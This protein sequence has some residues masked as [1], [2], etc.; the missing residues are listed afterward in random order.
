MIGVGIDIGTRALLAFR[1]GPA[2]PSYPDIRNYVAA[3]DSITDSERGGT[4][5]GG[6]YA[7]AAF[8]L[9][10]PAIATWHNIALSGSGISTLVD[11]AADT[12]AKLV[13][14]AANILSV[15]IGANH[16]PVTDEFLVPLAAYLDARRASGWYVL[17]GTL[18]PQTTK[19]D[20]NSQRAVANPELRL[21][22]TNGSIVP[23]KHADRIFDFAADPIMGLD[24][25]A[26]NLTYFADGL[27]PTPVGQAR[28]RDIFSPVLDAAMSNVTTAP[29]L[30][31]VGSYTTEAGGR[32]TLIQLRADRGVIWSISGDAE[33]LMQE[34]SR[35][36]LD[37]TTPGTYTTTITMTDGAGRTTDHEFTWDVVAP[38][39][40]Y[41]PN[42][43]I[44]G[45]GLLG[46]TGWPVDETLW[47]EVGVVGGIDSF[48]ILDKAGGGKEYIVQGNGGGFPQS[49]TVQ[50]PIESGATYRADAIVRQGTA[51]GGPTLRIDGATSAFLGTTD[52]VDTPVTGTFTG[53]TIAWVVMYIASGAEAGN[54]YV[55]DI[56]IRKV[57]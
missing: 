16:N 45:K 41:G 56:A 23:G 17:L 18:L 31:S 33:I 46:W 49:P 9:A 42:L 43:F 21:W 3:G 25:T 26:S 14:G 32:D 44:N 6:G 50:V 5:A 37:T 2:A 7:K 34:T 24:A 40:G 28:M 12:D 1:G 35:L 27:H 15:F 4:A 57:L 20:F 52:T 13:I 8:N 29:A 48:F 39:V 54:C 55:S 36:V 38:P 10:S 53:G 30:T 47:F 11:E 51:T 22:I 19:P